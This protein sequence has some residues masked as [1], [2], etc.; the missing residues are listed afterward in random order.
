M[1]E[2]SLDIAIESCQLYKTMTSLFHNDSNFV[3]GP[4]SLE[5][6]ETG[7]G[8]NISEDLTQ[9]NWKNNEV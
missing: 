3:D 8:L 7:V 6:E 1:S 2:P 4:A 5:T 9:L